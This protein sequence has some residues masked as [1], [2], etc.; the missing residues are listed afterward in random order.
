MKILQSLNTFLLAGILATVI[1]ILMETRKP[2]SLSDA[3]PISVEI[4]PSSQPVEV[5][6]QR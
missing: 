1:L 4:D 6:I 3:E 5:E 2:I